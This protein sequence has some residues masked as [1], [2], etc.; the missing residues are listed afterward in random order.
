MEADER[1]RQLQIDTM[2]EE[3]AAKRVRRAV[4]RQQH[5]G[6]KQ[7]EADEHMRQLQIETMEEELAAKRVRRVVVG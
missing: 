5:A 6:C 7:M 2:E 1:M 4:N 3:R